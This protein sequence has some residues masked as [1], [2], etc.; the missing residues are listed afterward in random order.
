MCARVK[1]GCRRHVDLLK[2]L[3]V[4]DQKCELVTVHFVVRSA[5]FPLGYMD[6]MFAIVDRFAKSFIHMWMLC[7]FSCALLF[8][9]EIPSLYP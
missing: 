9:L 7:G 4:P 5:L 8:L 1:D 3:V 2:P 6:A